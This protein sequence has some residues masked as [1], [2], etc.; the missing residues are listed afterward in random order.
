M[1][2]KQENR[3]VDRPRSVYRE[4]FEALVVAGIFLG[5]TNTFVLKTFF[6]PSASMEETLLIGDHLFV[7]RFVY[8]QGGDSILDKVIPTREIRRGDIVVF[9]SVEERGVD[10][11]KR[12]VG[13]PGDRVQ[14]IEKELHIN[15]LRVED[16]KYTQHK[17]N[18]TLSTERGYSADQA[19]R[20][21][22]SELTVP[23][24]NY[25]CLGDNR[26][27]SHDS[28]FWGTVPAHHIKGRA[29]LI[30]WSYGGETPDGVWRGWGHRL[31]QLAGTA[32]GFLTRTRWR[33]SFHLVR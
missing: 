7:N 21:N 27:L 16:S 17:D 12:C 24:G 33:R 13:I 32:T 11:V 9:R 8:G 19:R 4:Y 18:R 6:I 5:F 22:F 25:F 14:M 3:R 20:D 26:D 15:G 31:R 28:R 23:E 30:Y 10:L 2:E 1:K 29:F